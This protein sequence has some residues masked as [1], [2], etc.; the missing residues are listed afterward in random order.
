MYCEVSVKKRENRLGLVD[1]LPKVFEVGGCMYSFHFSEIITP[2]ECNM[3]FYSAYTA[4]PA[5]SP[6]K[7]TLKYIWINIYGF[8]R[9][10]I[11]GAKLF[12]Y[13][14]ES[15]IRIRR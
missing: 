6:P 8:I 3:I 12:V 11:C 15:I 5:P 2:N 14:I 9:A 13:A 7:A 10:D 1:L 4:F